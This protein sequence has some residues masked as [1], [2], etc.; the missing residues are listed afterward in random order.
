[1]SKK[2][3]KQ[4]RS[5]AQRSG[6]TPTG[7]VARVVGATA[8]SPS[9]TSVR[10]LAEHSRALADAGEWN[11]RS[12][13][14]LDYAALGQLGETAL[15][16][17][18]W[19]VD[20]EAGR[21][22]KAPESS[23]DPAAIRRLAEYRTSSYGVNRTLARLCRDCERPPSWVMTSGDLKKS[24][25]G[26]VD[27]CATCERC[28]HGYRGELD[29]D[30][31]IVAAYAPRASVLANHIRDRARKFLERERERRRRQVEAGLKAAQARRKGVA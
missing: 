22:G 24:R 18:D 31:S 13:C 10:A 3:R 20:W 12:R 27:P 25:P 9:R 2:S 26:A 7:D 6:A 17:T 8:P 15:R 5:T 11:A 21:T 4:D 23:V 14:A 29:A 28:L 19:L 1:M 16:H 30:L